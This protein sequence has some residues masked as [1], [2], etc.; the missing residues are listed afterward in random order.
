MI[1]D[2]VF[3]LPLDRSFSYR[4]PPD[5]PSRITVGQ[6]VR[7]PL[8]RRPRV[9][10]VVALRDGI[11]DSLESLLDLVDPVGLLSPVLVE[12]TRR[13]AN[14]SLSS[15]GSACAA[16]LPPPTPGRQSFQAPPVS[17]GN[18][19]SENPM[20]PILLS[21]GDREEVLLTR[22]QSEARQAGILLVTPEIEDAE[23]WAG[24]LDTALGST[25]LRLHSGRPE[26]ERYASWIQLA[27]GDAR[28]AVTTRAG[29]LAPIP[30]P[31]WVVVVDEHDPAHKSPATPRLHA[32]DVAEWRASA[33]GHRLVLTSATPSV[34]SW[35]RSEDGQFQLV[36]GRPAPW[37]EVRVVD[38]RGNDPIEPISR[39]LREAVGEALAA[40]GQGLL[41]AMRLGYAPALTCGECGFSPRC[42]DCRISLTFRRQ[43]RQLCCHL[44]RRQERARALCPRCRGRTLT[45]SGW[46]TE[47]IEEAARAAFPGVP[48]VRYDGESARGA[49]GRT[50]RR[51]ISRGEA[52]LVVGTRSALRLFPRD[53]LGAVGVISPDTLLHLPDFR[54]AERTFQLLWE[55]AERAGARAGRLVVQTHHP[56]HYALT[57]TA[58][59]DRMAF[60]QTELKFR[61]EL[62]YPPFSRLIR[63]VIRGAGETQAAALTERIR[64]DLAGAGAPGLTVY[65]PTPLRPAA[66][67]GRWQLIVK[68][69]RELPA[70]LLPALRPLLIRRGARGMTAEVDVDPIELR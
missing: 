13:V 52:R 39:S 69:E 5:L 48:V 56:D 23:A 47:R 12:L 31:A 50:L 33:E 66:R 46:G 15:W 59:Q 67:S 9:G 36:D 35:W 19:P 49:Q 43:S 2:V 1:A 26:G 62:A 30:A 4:V 61:A 51:L 40:G 6:R 25:P 55:A 37:P 21:G 54:A 17:R 20:S 42:P 63:I 65:G 10:V 32:R 44:C 7:A 34:E 58:H 45:A 24:R 29:L 18:P 22:L 8:Q 60:Y 16:F 14:E 70:R 53:A 27:L 3:D 64:H 11:G 28:V 38:L 57:A 68:G 41:L